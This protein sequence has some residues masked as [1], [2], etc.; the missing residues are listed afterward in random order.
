VNRLVLVRPGSVLMTAEVP[1][2]DDVPR[3]V[4]TILNPDRTQ[5]KLGK[6]TGQYPAS[7]AENRGMLALA[8][9]AAATI[10]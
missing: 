6:L 8:A 4:M 5:R 2:I 10:H 1:L 9:H 7:V 3:P